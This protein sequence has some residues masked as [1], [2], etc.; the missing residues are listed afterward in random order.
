MMYAAK[1][2]SPDN[3]CRMLMVIAD[4]LFEQNDFS[5]AKDY[6]QIVIDYQNIINSDKMGEIAR[7]R[8]KQCEE[9]SSTDSRVEK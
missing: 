5:V 9:S 2:K 4:S 6:Y 8:I 1:A 3:A 7:S